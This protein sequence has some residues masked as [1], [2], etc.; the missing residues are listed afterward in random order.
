M[1]QMAKPELEPDLKIMMKKLSA[2]ASYRRMMAAHEAGKPICVSSAGVP[3][4]LMFAMDVFPIYPESL[5]AI[6]SGIR[7]ADEFFNEARLREFST[8]VCSYTRC[9]LGISWT[10]KCAFGPIPEPDL[11]V[12]DVSVCC[13]H[14]T[15][16][17]YLEDHF[18]KPTFY[19]DQPATDD[20]DDPAYIDYYEDQIREMVTFIE[21]N[22]KSVFD[23]ERLKQ[24]VRYSDLTGLYWK[25]IMELRKHKPS[26]ASFRHLA[27]QILPLVTALGE[28]DAADF[29]KA[30][31]E[32]YE[33]Q[34][35]EGVT[36][37]EGGERYRLI[38]NGIPIWHHLQVIEYFEKKGAN[39][40][41]EPYTSLSW[42]NK[43]P[44]GRLDPEDP[45][46][47]LAVK[48]TNVLTNKPIEQRYKYFDE[49][50]KEY[51]VDGLVM[52]SNRSCRPMSIGQDEVVDLIRE[53]HD[54]PI[55]IFEG[56][57]ADPEG[58]S[59]Q[60]A[61]TKIDGFIEVLE[62]RK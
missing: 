15:W 28:K 6:S 14:V 24:T 54:I 58:F 5:A 43:T 36:P 4:E 56:D 35:R 9:G 31:H 46:R 38:W 51:D 20:P 3:S 59:W 2:G 27:G 40:V 12:T 33:N 49:A 52:F 10:N 47:T 13:L 8:S 30:Y 55:L 37:A 7:K 1:N 23:M 61:K 45:F 17:A 21:D 11:F 18:K 32:H 22:T 48:Y 25:K 39:F 60:D 42:G 34:I 50:I 16:W 29:Y 53:R 19:V 57:Q 44:S 62:A 26:P 41:W